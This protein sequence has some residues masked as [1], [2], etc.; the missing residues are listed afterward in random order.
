MQRPGIKHPAKEE[1][2]G[3]GVCVCVCVGGGGGGGSSLPAPEFSIAYSST[4]G[5]I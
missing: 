3:G 2:G 5:R 4:T 1:R